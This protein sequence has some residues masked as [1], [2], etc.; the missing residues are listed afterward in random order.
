MIILYKTLE[1]IKK[2][3]FNLLVA[4]LM[5]VIL[6]Q[7]CAKDPVIVDKPSVEKDTVWVTSA[8]TYVTQPTVVKTVPGI[9]G[10]EFIPDT[11]YSKLVLQYRN[12]VEQYIAKNIH[13]DSIKIDSIGYV[14][15]MDTVSKNLIVGRQTSYSFKYPI[16]T[17]TITLPPVTKNQ[18]Y[19]GGG[20]SVDPMQTSTMLNL[21]VLLKTKKDNIYNLYGG[22]STQGTYQVGVQSYWKIKLHK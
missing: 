17:N 20:V 5:L 11:N 8:N 6:F 15:I 12:L 4:I 7:R 16:I 10:K 2:N 3:F 9:P 19:Y 22:V 14:K 18:V 21:G 1:F 13:Q